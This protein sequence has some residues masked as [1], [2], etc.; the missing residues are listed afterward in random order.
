[1]NLHFFRPSVLLRDYIKQY[2]FYNIDKKSI[3][4]KIKFIPS[5]NP[6][7]VF[8]IGDSFKIYNRT[9]P[10]GLWENGN[11]IG[12]QQDSFYLLSPEGKL[13][14][15]CIIFHPAGF[16]RLF[17]KSTKDILNTSAAVEF[18]IKHEIFSR[19]QNLAEETIDPKLITVKLNDFFCKKLLLCNKKYDFIEY[20][21]EQIQKSKGGFSI[22]ELS[23][24]SHTCERNYRRRFTELVG[25]SPKKYIQIIRLQ[26]IFNTINSGLPNKINWA[27]FSYNLGYYDQMHF[28][29]EFKKFCG[30]S[31]GVYFSE[32]NKDEKLIERELFSVT[33]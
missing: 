17:N 18:F 26:N 3:P 20:S 21:I 27:D 22:K 13:I 11:I 9:H 2:V 33:Y 30:E 6:F 4:E 28:I 24:F 5:G 15:F 32:Y 19:I 23:D 25:I 29:K 12:G 31:P 10:E 1:M 14:N 7:M 16:Y 8:N